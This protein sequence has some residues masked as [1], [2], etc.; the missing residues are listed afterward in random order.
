MTTKTLGEII[1]ILEEMPQDATVCFAF[2]NLNPTTLDS[3]RGSYN[4]LALGYG[5]RIRAGEWKVVDFIKHCKDAIG[6]TYTGWKGGDFTM[7]ENTPVWVDNCG[8]SSETGISN[9]TY[10]GYYYVRIHTEY[11][12]Y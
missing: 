7:G 10:D 5:D 12:E 4:E 9:I 8:E 6:S 11:M 2:G 3:W 1:K